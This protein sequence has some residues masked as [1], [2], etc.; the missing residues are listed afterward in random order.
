MTQ[1]KSKKKP[2]VD[3]RAKFIALPQDQQDFILHFFE[4]HNAA[5]TFF[6]FSDI[7]L[8]FLVVYAVATFKVNI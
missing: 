6:V 8:F 3:L 2:Q 5:Q 1:R 7:T 4:L